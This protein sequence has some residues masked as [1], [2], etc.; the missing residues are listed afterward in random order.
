MLR[1]DSNGALWIPTSTLRTFKNGEVKELTFIDDTTKKRS[2]HA[3]H[4]EIK[5]DG[6]LID[7][8]VRSADEPKTKVIQYTTLG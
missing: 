6:K 7:Y 2:T 8:T 1:K 3:I 5:R 4:V